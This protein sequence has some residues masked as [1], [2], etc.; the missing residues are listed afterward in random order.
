MIHYS[1]PP[2]YY[3]SITLKL[4]SDVSKSG[5]RDKVHGREQFPDPL[6]IITTHMLI[7]NGMSRESYVI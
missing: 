5:S 1:S 3:V 7:M 2:Y 6:T 4:G